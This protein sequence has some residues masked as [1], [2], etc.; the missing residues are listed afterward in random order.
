S[1]RRDDRRQRQEREPVATPAAVSAAGPRN[2]RAIPTG[3]EAKLA[4]GLMLF[5]VSQFPR[6]IAGLSRSLG[7]PQVAAVNDSASSVE[8]FVGW[9]IAWYSY[10][11]DLGDA[12][13]PVEQS[14][15]GN[16]SVELAGTV[17]D[18][19]AFSDE[20]GRL[21]LRESAAQSDSA[22]ARHA[23]DSAPPPGSD[24]GA[25]VDAGDA[26]T[27]APGHDDAT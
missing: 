8:V 13:E 12:T 4:Q 5:N 27:T 1:T 7:E 18:W 24:P 25:S 10:R 6:S 11:I 23:S 15:R 22:P 21:F 26:G 9:D 19:N 17:D 20:H 2:V 14:G 16:D 3:P